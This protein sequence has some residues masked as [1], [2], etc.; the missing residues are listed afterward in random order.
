MAG[1]ALSKWRNAQGLGI[2][3]LVAIERVLGGLDDRAGRTRAGLSDLEMQNLR[4]S[5]ARALAAAI[6]SIT[7]NGAMALRREGLNGGWSPM[8][9]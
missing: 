2:A 9:C 6:I 7:M 5:A 4:T 1:D 3:E 8:L